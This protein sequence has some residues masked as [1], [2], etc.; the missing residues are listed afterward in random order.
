MDIRWI[1]NFILY[2]IYLIDNL[3]KH[4]AAQKDILSCINTFVQ[5]LYYNTNKPNEIKKKNC[6][7]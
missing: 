4:K 5:Q 3:N 7:L 6:M 2:K 1:D